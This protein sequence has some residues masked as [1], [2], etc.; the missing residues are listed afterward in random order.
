V[1]LLQ[2][3]AAVEHGFWFARSPEF[4]HSDLIETLVWMRV[5]GDILFALG[6]VLLALFFAKLFLGRREA[7]VAAAA[8]E[9]PT[10]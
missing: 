5:P 8:K 6:A 7:T 9:A 10:A 3:K 2:V 1:G 4:L